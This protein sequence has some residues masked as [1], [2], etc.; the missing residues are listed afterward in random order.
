MDNED[1][2]PIDDS[3]RS[4]QDGLPID[5]DSASESC[6]DTGIVVDAPCLIVYFHICMGRRALGGCGSCRV[7]AVLYLWHFR[8]CPISIFVLQ[9]GRM[10][11]GTCNNCRTSWAT[12]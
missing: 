7:K 9:R 6:D 8:R 2:L 12:S 4:D 11:K 3:E 5:V 10:Q 1:A